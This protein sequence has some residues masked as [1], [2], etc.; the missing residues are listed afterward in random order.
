M[1]STSS[2]HDTYCDLNFVGTWTPLVPNTEVSRIELLM[3]LAQAQRSIGAPLANNEDQLWD[4]IARLGVLSVGQLAQAFGVARQTIY[5]RLMRDGIPKPERRV[6]SQ[7]ALNPRGFETMLAIV[8]IAQRKG[9]E[10]ITALMLEE[11][12]KCGKPGA[13]K[14]L[15]GI[16]YRS[17]AP[18]RRLVRYTANI[19]VS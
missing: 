8:K 5:I 12:T 6:F 15:T 13:V 14:L 19:E 16:D 2:Q 3:L 4:K 18:L 1:S 9:V 11:L 10:H 17:Y 7:G